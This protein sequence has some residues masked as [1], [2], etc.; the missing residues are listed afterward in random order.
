M[1]LTL[2]LEEYTE[3]AASRR[4]G[5]GAL[6]EM[7]SRVIFMRERNALTAQKRQSEYMGHI[8]A[9]HDHAIWSPMRRGQ[10][11]KNTPR[12]IPANKH[13]EEALADWEEVESSAATEANMRRIAPIKQGAKM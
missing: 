3:A 10:M 6:F 4:G 13:T 5:A 7:F 12:H 9:H 1:A 11:M 2:H 8:M